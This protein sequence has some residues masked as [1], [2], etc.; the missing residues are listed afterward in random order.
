[1][2]SNIRI[3]RI[4]NFCGSE[5][6]ARTTVTKYCQQ[7]CASR[8]YKARTQ[9]EAVQKSNQETASVISAP[10]AKIQ[11]KDFLN[12]DEACQILGV[13][14]WTLSRAIKA[15]RLQAT[16]FGKRVVIK[17]SAIDQMFS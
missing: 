6:T 9:Q 13:S 5:F 8:A 3:L 14:R 4:C 10:L 12:I 2:S 16:R 17:R 15:K 7:M 1:M 11:A